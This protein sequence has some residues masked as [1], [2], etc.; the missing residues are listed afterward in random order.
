MMKTSTLGAQGDALQSQFADI[1]RDFNPVHI[2]P[3]AARSSMFG[4][5]IVHGIHGTIRQL[6]SL[7][8]EG[9]LDWI[10]PQTALSMKVDYR[11]PTYPSDIV[12]LKIQD[13]GPQHCQIVCHRQSDMFGRGAMR[14]AEARQQMPSARALNGVGS[15]GVSGS[16]NC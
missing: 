6:D 7:I 5:K 11:Q 10:T 14:Q 3:I 1:V 2:D 4:Q 15:N 16:M 12:K 8:A 13:K 9:V